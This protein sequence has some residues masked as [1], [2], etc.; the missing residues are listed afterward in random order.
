M[1][2]TYNALGG[3]SPSRTK[4]KQNKNTASDHCVPYTQNT[5]CII[6]EAITLIIRIE[7][8]GPGSTCL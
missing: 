7:E 3:I 1:K 2:N 5:Q 4:A 6:D 8:V